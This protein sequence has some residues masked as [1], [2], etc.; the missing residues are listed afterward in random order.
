MNVV[1]PSNMDLSSQNDNHVQNPPVSED[2]GAY[3][4]HWGSTRVCSEKQNDLLRASRSRS[5][6]YSRES[7]SDDGRGRNR[8]RAKTAPLEDSSCHE[9]ANVELNPNVIRSFCVAE[10]QQQLQ[11]ALDSRNDCKEN[12][13]DERGPYDGEGYGPMLSPKF[14]ANELKS[15]NTII[16]VVSSE[17]SA[18][19]DEM[20]FLP[21]PPLPPFGLLPFPPFLSTPCNV[22]QPQYVSNN[23]SGADECTDNP[24]AFD[25]APPN[26][27]SGWMQSTYHSPAPMLPPPLPSCNVSTTPTNPLSSTA[28]LA[29]SIPPPVP[30]PY[31][32]SPGGYPPIN[33]PLPIPSPGGYPSVD[34]PPLFPSLPSSDLPPTT[35]SHPPIQDLPPPPSDFIFEVSQNY[36]DSPYTS[37]SPFLT[38]NHSPLDNNRHKQRQKATEEYKSLSPT[39]SS[40][41]GDA[42]VFQPRNLATGSQLLGDLDAT[43][44]PPSGFPDMTRPP[45]GL[46]DSYYSEMKGAYPSG[47]DD[48]MPSYY[49]RGG[50]GLGSSEESVVDASS[51]SSCADISAS[52]YGNHF[53][54]TLPTNDTQARI[55]F[56]VKSLSRVSNSGCENWVGFRRAERQLHRS[57]NVSGFYS[58][59]GGRGSVSCNPIARFRKEVREG[60]AAYIETKDEHCTINM[61]VRSGMGFWG[62]LEPC[63]FSSATMIPT[64]P[65]GS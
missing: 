2:P 64:A 10:A 25:A 18:A 54:N 37:S 35:Y 60:I 14:S 9:P 63:L 28:F 51:T 19:K 4:H 47:A 29:Y 39:S 31:S 59:N 12:M 40:L 24:S 44:C 16:R 17:N 56:Q 38:P 1:R 61:M 65:P 8:R 57:N 3:P 58:G 21:P 62:I 13:S 33:I 7:D 36:T 43:R 53:H 23:V 52:H 48:S 49:G 50:V 5:A 6:I 46:D 42:P 32:E 34:I 27:T 30:S 11:K 41:N 26:E 15:E 22:N 20:A 45:P 55:S